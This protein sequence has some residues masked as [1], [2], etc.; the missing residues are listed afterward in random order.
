MDAAAFKSKDDELQIL[1]RENH[2]MRNKIVNI[3]QENQILEADNKT[4]LGQTKL[5]GRLSPIEE[6][7]NL[8]QQV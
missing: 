1:H 3:L 7:C 4:F 6:K 2:E 8:K 5:D